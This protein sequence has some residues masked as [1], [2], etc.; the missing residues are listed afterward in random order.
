MKAHF[1][2]KQYRNLLSTL[3]KRSKQS[4]FTNYFQTNISDLKSTWKGI[5]KLISLKR[6]SNSVPSAIIENNIRLTKP[7]DI[8]NVF[9]KYLI[10]SNSIQSKTKFSRNKFHDFLPDIYINSFFI[11]PV[12]KIEVQKF[13]IFF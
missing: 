1:K 5:K 8:A 2:Y 6:A 7:K 9:N 12:D 10:I 3:L 11:K 13:F 4:Y